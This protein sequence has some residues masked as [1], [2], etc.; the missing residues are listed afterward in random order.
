MLARYRIVRGKRPP[1]DPLPEGGRVDVRKHTH[2]VLSP[3]P[4]SVIAFLE[5]PSDASFRR[6]SAD[7]RRLLAARFAERRAEF[8]ALAAA[9]SEGD[10]HIGCN[11]P[12]AKN[13]V[14]HCHTVIA[15]HFMKKKYPKLR[16]VFP[17]GT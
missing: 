6:F 9:A 7:Y 15:L 16:V 5:D 10:V 2:H 4:E 8:D 3:N 14:G 12:T 17:K 11:C 13:P 1:G